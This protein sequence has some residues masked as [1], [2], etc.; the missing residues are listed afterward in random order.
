MFTLQVDKNG[1]E[2]DSSKDFVSKPDHIMS[3]ILD[4]LT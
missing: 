2:N 1:D 3:G 4:D